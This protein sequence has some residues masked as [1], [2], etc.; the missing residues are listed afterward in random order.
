MHSPSLTRLFFG[1]VSAGALAFALRQE[2]WWWRR[3]H[4]CGESGEVVDQLSEPGKEGGTA[5]YPIIRMGHGAEGIR[6]QSA[7][8]RM[9]PIAVGTAVRILRDP[10]TGQPEVYSSA[11]RILPTLGLLGFAW[12]CGFVAICGRD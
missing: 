6:F 4:A 2:L 3:R 5:Y 8:A 9:K 10:E 12:L 11:R 7:Y 1:F